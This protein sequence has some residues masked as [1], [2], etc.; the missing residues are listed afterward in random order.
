MTWLS[1][2][3]SPQAVAWKEPCTASG[4][5]RRQAQ[6]RRREAGSWRAARAARPPACWACNGRC[7][8]TRPASSCTKQKQGC[9]SR[10]TNWRRMDRYV[11]V[12]E[13]GIGRRGATSSHWIPP[14]WPFL[15]VDRPPPS[16]PPS[17]SGGLFPSSSVGSAWV[18]AEGAS[19][20]ERLQGRNPRSDSNSALRRRRRPGLPDLRSRSRERDAASDRPTQSTKSVSG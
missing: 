19:S 3:P 5:R 13:A 17:S 6:S 14:A 9:L 11:R 10:V 1:H 8:G 16:R 15:R 4:A 2:V 18:P 12:R 7:K 20:K